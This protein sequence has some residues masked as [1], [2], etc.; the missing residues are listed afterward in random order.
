MAARAC[1]DPGASSQPTIDLAAG[2]AAGDICAVEA[3]LGKLK[4]VAAL[5]A[6]AGAAGAALA[7]E[8]WGALALIA[9]FL[10]DAHGTRG[11]GDPDS[12]V[13]VPTPEAAQEIRKHCMAKT[14]VAGEPAHATG[15]AEKSAIGETH[16]T[17]PREDLVKILYCLTDA[18]AHATG[19]VKTCVIGEI[20]AN[21]DAAAPRPDNGAPRSNEDLTKIFDCLV[22]GTVSYNRFTIPSEDRTNDGLNVERVKAEWRKAAARVEKKHAKGAARAAKKEKKGGEGARGD[23]DASADEDAS[24]D[25]DA[26]DEDASE[27]RK[28]TDFVRTTKADTRTQPVTGFRLEEGPRSW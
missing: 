14:G 15:D 26:S 21:C 17:V 8:H 22:D 12:I 10:R 24:G 20:H 3:A 16:A 13:V 25:E 27:S 2:A 5:S 19:D 11:G 18:G 1:R 28:I 23:E 6:A 9:G 4:G 7:A